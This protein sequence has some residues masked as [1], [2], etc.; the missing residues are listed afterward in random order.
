MRVL[1]D[2]DPDESQSPVKQSATSNNGYGFGGM[3]SPDVVQTRLE[4]LQKSFP[5]KVKKC[6]KKYCYRQKVRLLHNLTEI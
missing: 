6:C 1:S 5:N 3:P 4:L 2:S